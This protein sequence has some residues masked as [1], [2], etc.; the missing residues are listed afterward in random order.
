L[1]DHLIDHVI[2]LVG[3]RAYVTDVPTPRAPADACPEPAR[4]IRIPQRHRI[5][6]EAVLDVAFHGGS[7][8][9]R[10]AEIAARVGVPR[11]SLENT[12]QALVRAGVLVAQRGPRGGYRLGRERRRIGLGE[13]VEAL[14]GLDDA[15][16]ANDPARPAL[17]SHL[18][19]AVIG[20]VAEAAEQALQAHLDTLN[21][22]DLCR[23]ARERGVRALRDDA[24]DFAI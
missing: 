3:A 1:I 20:P 4:M 16:A 17:S 12:L 5:A 6:M 15:D 2:D 11:R 22:D 10:G 18:G 8:P 9:V 19:R 23:Q 21:V 7:A 14:D 13:I 24:A